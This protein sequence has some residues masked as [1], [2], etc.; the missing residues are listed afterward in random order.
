MS[1]MKIL[2]NNNYYFND[3]KFSEL[4]KSLTLEVKNNIID[5]FTDIENIKKHFNL[6][7]LEAMKLLY[8]NNNIIHPLLY[9]FDNIIKINS[10]EKFDNISYY[11]Y[12]S[13]LITKSPNII[14]YYSIQFIIKIN[15]YSINS[16][17]NIKKIIISKI[18]IDLIKYYRG[19]EEFGNNLNEIKKIEES[20]LQVIEKENDINILK[21]LNL[22]I[23]EIKSKTVDKIYLEIIIHLIK[24]KFE[25]YKYIENVLKELDIESINI[26]QFMFNEIKA[27]LDNKE[28]DINK[29]LISK[30]D[31]FDNKKINLYYILIKYILK[32]RIY[33]YQINFFLDFRKSIIKYLK[34]NYFKN[35]K[36]ENNERLEYIIKILIDSEYYLKKYDE[37]KE[38]NE[39]NNPALK[40][41]SEKEYSTPKDQNNIINCSISTESESKSNK[42][43]IKEYKYCVIIFIAIIGNHIRKKSQNTKEK[44]N[45][46][47]TRK[48]EYTAD[49]VIETSKFFISGGTNNNIIFYLKDSSLIKIY[50]LGFPDNFPGDW[51]YNIL[52]KEENHML[53]TQGKGI[54]L[55]K[56]KTD[57]NNST[58]YSKLEKNTLFTLQNGENYIVCC[59]NEILI[60]DSNLV[61]NNN[62]A[63][64]KVLLDKYTSKA[65]IKINNFGI[66]K[67]NKIC[68]MGSDHLLIYNLIR[69]KRKKPVYNNKKDEY[70]LVYSPNGLTILSM[71]IKDE[72]L[73][74]IINKKLLLCACKKYIKGQKNGILLLMNF[75]EN[76]DQNNNNIDIKTYFFDTRNFE[77][78][79]FCQILIL[80]NIIL[81]KKNK[82]TNYFLAG[83]FEKEK[84]RGII[85]LFKVIYNYEKSESSIEFIQD[86]E[87]INQYDSNE[88]IILKKPI[89]CITQSSSD[90]NLLV[91]CW[92]GN[93]YLLS[94]LNIEAYL[95]FDKLFEKDITFDD[96]DNFQFFNK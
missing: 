81:Q 72:K 17:N 40:N 43:E 76:N 2:S 35:F 21:E 56:V 7:E 32:E 77:V 24:N 38:L 12:L 69:K 59:Q 80:T 25:E 85:K 66:F 86:I 90:E 82:K 79:C 46:A 62:F 19:L 67:S 29:N 10:I 64:E 89:S 58:I 91:T 13:L 61:E 44:E 28:S 34:S 45:T 50:N 26:T 22:S 8:F 20:N 94:S 33:I 88:F 74:K 68:S 47:N 65:G 57:K 1:F 23:K 71:D 37:I 70:S 93:V 55:I 48:K 5:I 54:N 36:K 53:V 52:E 31:L 83:G 15:E 51:V 11:Y 27:L 16:K 84:K 3:L 60:Y 41:I 92:D 39:N 63:Q 96:L 42:N 30:E 95:N 78:Y 14:Y 9:E 75:E 6:N 73:N 49:F 18:I 87:I 4:L